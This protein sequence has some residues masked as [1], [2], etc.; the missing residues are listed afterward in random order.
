MSLSSLSADDRS[1]YKRRQFS[2]GSNEFGSAGLALKFVVRRTI[3]ESTP[4][5]KSVTIIVAVQNFQLSN[6]LWKFVHGASKLINE[7]RLNCQKRVSILGSCSDNDS[8]Q[9]VLF[10]WTMPRRLRLLTLTFP[11]DSEHEC[12]MAISL[13]LEIHREIAQ[14][15]QISFIFNFR[16]SFTL[17]YRLYI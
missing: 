15:S 7:P 10:G 8:F 12:Q 17:G 16:L 6:P 9:R 3:P 11:D 5:S 2:L 14:L 13:V 1:L 4:A